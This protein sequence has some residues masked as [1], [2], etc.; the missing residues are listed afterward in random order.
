MLRPR[1]VVA[2]HVRLSLP[3]TPQRHVT[4]FQDRENRGVPQTP[5]TK[6]FHISTVCSKK[7]GL[8][9]FDCRQRSQLLECQTALV[10]EPE[11]AYA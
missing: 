8:V 4:T 3:A 2:R 11:L 6:S 1:A 7:N 10:P 5:D 9:A